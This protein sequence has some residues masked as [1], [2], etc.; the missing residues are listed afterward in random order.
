VELFCK[1]FYLPLKSQW[2]KPQMWK[3]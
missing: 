3:M 2:G 1:E